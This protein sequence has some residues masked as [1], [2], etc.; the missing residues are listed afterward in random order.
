[1]EFLKHSLLSTLFLSASAF[2]SQT[3]QER[4][5]SSQLTQAVAMVNKGAGTMLDEETRLDSAATFSNYIIYTNTMV[6]YTAD[7][8]DP[9]EF[10]NILSE[11]VIKPLCTTKGLEGFIETGVIMVYRYLDKN[12]KFI[13]EL[14]KDMS[15]CE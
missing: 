6:N 7:Q 14:S 1:M 3:A 13:S 5:L 10:S 15:T 9:I 2:A 4:E 12:G 8:L 11:I